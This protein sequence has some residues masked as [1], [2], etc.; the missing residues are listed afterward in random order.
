[1]LSLTVD[2]DDAVTCPRRCIHIHMHMN[3]CHS[4]PVLLDIVFRK[5]ICSS[6]ACRAV[7]T[8]PRCKGPWAEGWCGESCIANDRERGAK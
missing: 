8:F 3:F 7:G 2:G 1:M 4:Q 5:V 6:S